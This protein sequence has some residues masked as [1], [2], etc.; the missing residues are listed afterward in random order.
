MIQTN[1]I[2]IRSVYKITKCFMEP[3][4]EPRTGRWPSSVRDVDSFGNM[5]LT[6]DDKKSNKH[7][8][9]TTDV[10]EIYDGKEFDLDDEISTA[11]WEAI[12]FSKRIAQDRA[13]RNELGALTIDGNA[14]RYGTAEFY[15]ERPGFETKV[16]NN[17][18]REI[19]KAIGFIQDD[20]PEQLYQKVRL[21]GNAMFGVPLSDVEDYLVTIAEKDPAKIIDLYTGGDTHLRLFLLDAIDKRIIYKK[22]SIYYYSDILLG[23]SDSAVINWFKNPANKLTFG[24]LKR[25]VYPELEV[26]PK[27]SNPIEIPEPIIEVSATKT[28][29]TA[30]KKK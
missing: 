22:D 16:K 18:R 19:H 21:L 24:L 9:K 6:D 4:K 25:E 8:I 29:A 26:A 2:I 17:K 15:I 30:A 13:E 20:S 10:I 11:Q 7:F 1:K 27:T 12:K 23:A 5:I 14:L 3:A 28:T